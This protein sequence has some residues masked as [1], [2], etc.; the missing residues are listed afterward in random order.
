[1]ATIVTSQDLE[2]W[3]VTDAVV[4][5]VVVTGG[6]VI[7]VTALAEG[8]DKSTGVGDDGFVVE[9]DLTVVVG[10]GVGLGLLS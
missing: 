1:M 9:V 10:S 7:F 5:A 4:G 8:L 2:A 3:V 6:V